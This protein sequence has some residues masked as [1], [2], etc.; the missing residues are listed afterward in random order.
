VINL[1]ESICLRKKR[2][3]TQYRKSCF[4]RIAKCVESIACRLSAAIHAEC[5]SDR[6]REQPAEAA[7]EIEI[8]RRADVDIE[9]Q[10]GIAVARSTDRGHS[11]QS[12][13]DR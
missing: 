7:T 2:T 9:R 5:E 6:T 4:G 12:H 8:D 1:S 10:T 11:S 3:L 13:F